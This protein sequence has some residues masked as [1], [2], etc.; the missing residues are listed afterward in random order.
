MVT[1]E[2]DAHFWEETLAQMFTFSCETPVWKTKEGGESQIPVYLLRI[3]SVF[4]IKL[5]WTT[6]AAKKY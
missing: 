5:W 2:S 6:V 1:S 3:S 4:Y